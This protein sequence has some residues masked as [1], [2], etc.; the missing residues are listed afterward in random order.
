MINQQP[1]WNMRDFLLY[2]LIIG[3]TG[4]NFFFRK[5]KKFLQSTSFLLF[6]LCKFAPEIEEKF[7]FRKYIRAFWVGLESSIPWNIRKIFFGKILEIFSE[8]VFF[9]FFRARK[10]P[11]W[12]IIKNFFSKNKRIFFKLSARR[13]HLPKYKKHFF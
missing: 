2:G 1:F 5:Y 13:Y 10:V 3:Q 8:C 9:L 11:S 6:K 12:N 4:E 7:I